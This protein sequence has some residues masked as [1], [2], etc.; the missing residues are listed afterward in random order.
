MIRLIHGDCLE[1]LPTLPSQ[2][3]DLVLTDPPYGIAYRPIRTAGKPDH[4]WVR[5]AGDARFDPHF[6]AAWLSEAY[7]LLRPDSHLYVFCADHHLGELRSLVREAGF[8]LKRTLVWHKNAWTMG[9]LR[10]DYGHQTEFIVFAHKGR[11]E[12]TPPRTGNILAFPRVAARQL[13]HPTEKPA[14]LLRHLIRKSCPPG[15]T[16]LDPFAGSGSTGVAARNEGRA[17]VLIESD[18]THIRTTQERLE[19]G[20]APDR[21]LRDAA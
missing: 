19:H 5:I 8:T 12:L 21:L 13:R 17:S 4:P 16:V 20:A 2:S 11:R 18:V 3:V 14:E 10:G 1:I 6:Y 15:G 9:D 7:R